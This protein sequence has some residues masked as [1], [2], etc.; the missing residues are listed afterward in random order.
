L[1][2]GGHRVFDELTSSHLLLNI[3]Q[4]QIGIQKHDG[5]ADGVD[6]V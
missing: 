4:M 5:V 3:C 1:L 6:N 2:D